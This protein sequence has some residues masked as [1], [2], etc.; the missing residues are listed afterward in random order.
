MMWYGM[1]Y[2]MIYGMIYDMIYRVCPKSHEIY[3]FAALLLVAACSN[4]LGEVGGGDPYL[5]SAP[6]VSLLRESEESG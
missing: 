5:H 3:F 2:D 4:R 1:I 6:T